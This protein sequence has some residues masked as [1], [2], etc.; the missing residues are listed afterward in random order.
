MPWRGKTRGGGD[1]DRS[2]SLSLFSS[3]A[4]AAAGDASVAVLWQQQLMIPPLQV[5]GVPIYLAQFKNFTGKKKFSILFDVVPSTDGT[6]VQGGSSIESGVLMIRTISRISLTAPFPLGATL[7]NR[8]GG[9]DAQKVFHSAFATASQ[10]RRPLGW[11]SNQLHGRKMTTL[12]R[13]HALTK[14]IALRNV[15]SRLVA[16]RMSPIPRSGLVGGPHRCSHPTASLLAFFSTRPDNH[17]GGTPKPPLP[18]P[19]SHNR[20]AQGVGFLGAASVLFGKTKYVLAALKVTKLASLGSMV[21]SMGAYSLVFGWPYAVGMVGLIF[22]HEC[23]HAAVMV[24][25]GMPFTPMV[26]I[27][28]MGA[29]IATKEH[30]RDAWEDALIA[31]GGPVAGSLAAGAV[32]VAAS[33]TQSQLLYALADFGYLIN[34]FNLLPIGSMDGGRWVGALSK[35]V[36][37]VGTGLGGYI[38][39]TGA[40]ANPLFYLI[41]LAGGYETFQRFW[42]PHHLPPNFYKITTGQRVALTGGYFGLVVALLVAMDAN[43]R[44]QKSPERIVREQGGEVTWDTSF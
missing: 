20:L 34:L 16:T 11:W 24:S 31:A 35:Y 25:R 1:S 18:P 42:N 41:W 2:L 7:W 21:L 13:Y 19:S 10:Q 40:V 5:G 6:S 14:S 38:A 39:Y 23:G 33:A 28:F 43:H 36:G 29:V 44:H 12:G 27:P 9:G 30:P 37:V 32:A 22:V 4:A 3:R 8:V 17:T 15:S 26:F